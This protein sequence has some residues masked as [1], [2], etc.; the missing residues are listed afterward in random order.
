[1]KNYKLLM[2]V[3]T[4][5]IVSILAAGVSAIDVDDCPDGMVSYWEFDNSLV[6]VLG[7][8]D[9]TMGYYG[10]YVDGFINQGLYGRRGCSNP[11]AAKV[12]DFPNLDSFTLESWIKPSCSSWQGSLTLTKWNGGYGGM[13]FMFFTN[14]TPYGSSNYK[15]I[16]HIKRDADNSLS[17][18]SP[19]TYACNNWYHVVAL[20][21]RG[22]VLSLFVNGEEVA[23][24]EDNVGS[25]ANEYPLVFHGYVSGGCG[26]G[27]SAITMDEVAIYDRILSE[28]EIQ[29]HY[30]NGLDG[31]GYCVILDEDGDGYNAE[32]D[33][34]DTNAAINPGAVEMPG[35]DVD[36]NCDEEI[37]CN[38]A[39]DWRN[40]G[41]YVSC[42]AHAAEAL[43]E[44]EL[45]TE[46]EKCAI[47]SAAAQ[48]DVGKNQDR[49]RGGG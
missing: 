29:Q 9:A 27:M 23:S 48:S 5:F 44:A 35:N 7:N 49:N 40:H 26:W 12:D 14:P 47:V 42:V 21:D 41:A 33:C 37:L 39:A 34:D 46:E 4:A 38:S 1:M 24:A 31:M 32:D 36:E 13:G 8:Y 16:M 15:F 6:D 3:L 11:Y 19:S 10:S 45:I 2:L 28:D 25:I 18:T 20:R 30:Q 22:N 43:L 17:V